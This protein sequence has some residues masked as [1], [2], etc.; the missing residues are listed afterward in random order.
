MAALIKSN[1]PLGGTVGILGLTY[2]P[3]VPLILDSP[4]IRLIE[5]LGNI[6]VI[7]HDPLLRDP[8]LPPGTR[9]AHSMARCVAMSDV[10]VVVMPWPE[11]DED[12]LAG[13]IVIDC[14]RALKDERHIAFGRG[15]R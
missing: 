10:I 2:K 7:A 15:P 8:D 6:P 5:V 14:W 13:K 1:L 9:W 11:L 3:G 4:G 12:L